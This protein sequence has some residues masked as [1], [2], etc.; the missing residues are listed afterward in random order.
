L[1]SERA[2]APLL[3]AATGVLAGV[4]MVVGDVPAATPARWPLLVLALAA[5]VAGLRTA[6][7]RRVLLCLLAGLAAGGAQG[8]AAERR[9][10]EL[11]QAV[12]DDAVVRL[13]CHVL[14]GWSRTTWGYRT[15]VR[16]VTAT[17]AGVPVYLPRRVRLEV[18]GEPD[19][20]RLPAPGA[21]VQGLASLRGEPDRPLLVASSRRLLQTEGPSRGLPRWRDALASGLLRAADVDAARIRAAEL[22]A[23]LALGRRD[24]IPVE[25]RDVW[26][27]SGFAHLLAVSGLHVGLVGGLAWLA[28]VAIGLGP[29]AARLVVLATLPGYA[30]LAG[31]SPSA[32]RAALMGIAYLLARLAGRP[33]LPLAAVL[34]AAT[35]M[36]L[37]RPP[38]VFEPGFQLTVLITAGLVRWVP[39]LAGVLPGPRWLAGAAAV[40]VV[41][42]LVAAPVVAFHFGT[43]RPGAVLANMAIPLLLAPLLAAALTAVAMAPIWAAGAALVLDLVATLGRTTLALGAPGR[44]IELA[45]PPLPAVAVAALAVA[46]WLAIRPGRW[47]RWGAAA[48]AATL[49]SFAAW[50][51]LLPGPPAPSVTLLP[52]GDGLAAVVAGPDS[53][54]LVDGGRLRD[55]ARSMLAAVG[56]RGLDAAIASHGDDDHIGGLAGVLT[57]TPPGRLLLP[58]WLTGD[59]RAVPLLRAARAGRTR[60][61]PV[62]RGSV[63][64]FASNR[65]EVLWPPAVGPPA[66]ENE[67]S[68]VARV[69]TGAGTILVTSDV[70]RSTERRLVAGADLRSQVLLAGHHGSR[71]STGPEL[72]AAARPDVILIPAGPRNTTHH[73]SPDL[74]RRLEARGIPYRYPARDGRCAARPLAGRWRPEP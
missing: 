49:A 30:V 74:L 24:L 61:L 62:A 72:L 67:R 52:V 31:A 25:R 8:L 34:I 29:T 18:R 17:R 63:I 66:A 53:T 44:A 43:L 27:R 21:T 35:A 56:V 73:P 6:G 2:V 59:A 39:P 45:A 54:L 3:Y 65:V 9:R 16:T 15:R 51:I 50:W 4:L 1:S 42:Q 32:V 69:R 20:L 37:A 64:A 71:T 28:A 33:V 38:L 12:D 46:G 57:T 26:R 55:E 70:G 58:S 11:E 41:A 10:G 68:L 13:T 60:V 36:V 22:A 40:P 47:G 14:E 7:R 48:W 19:P 5:G 23:G